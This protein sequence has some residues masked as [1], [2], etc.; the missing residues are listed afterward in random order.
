MVL[1]DLLAQLQDF[2]AQLSGLLESWGYIGLFLATFLAATIVP[3]PSEIVFLF[4][5]T[6][7]PHPLLDGDA[8]ETTLALY[9]WTYRAQQTE[10]VRKESAKMGPPIGFGFLPAGIRPTYC[11]FI[12]IAALRPQEKHHFHHI[13]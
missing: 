10:A 7:G 11:H 9:L 1:L 12:R 3:F 5:I 13:G 4:C 8:G 2:Y 6:G